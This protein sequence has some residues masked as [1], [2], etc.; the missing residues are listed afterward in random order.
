MFG[1]S[2]LCAA[3]GALIRAAASTQTLGLLGM[4]TPSSDKLAVLIDADNA[5]ASVA[6]EL[7][8]ESPDTG[9]ATVKRAYGDWTSPDLNGWKEVLHNL[10]I[11]PIQ[12][13][14]YTVGKTPPTQH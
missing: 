6:T 4:A 7:L 1:L 10:A 8:R 13:F 14:R 3:T 11:R 5:Q 12:Q 9:T 2:A